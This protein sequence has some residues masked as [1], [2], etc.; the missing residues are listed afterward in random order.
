[1][2]K[3]KVECNI[4][5]T[6]SE[7]DHRPYLDTSCVLC[8]NT[9]W[10]N[11]TERTTE[12]HLEPEGDSVQRGYADCSVHVESHDGA[13]PQISPGGPVIP[14]CH[15]GGVGGWRWLG[16]D[17]CQPSAA[18]NKTSRTLRPPGGLQMCSL[19]VSCLYLPPSVAGGGYIWKVPAL[20]WFWSD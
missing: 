10:D 17:T 11:R 3:G 12:H 14:A 9:R 7:S 18:N 2:E 13:A 4:N 5:I 16:R 6:S 20:T 15:G 19:G 1:M 8:D